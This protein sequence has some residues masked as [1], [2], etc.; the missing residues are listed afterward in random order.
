[1]APTL[2]MMSW[3]LVVAQRPA[4]LAASPM[5][6]VRAT[7]MGR[8][9]PRMKEPRARLMARRAAEVV[10]VRNLSV[11][12]GH[13]RHAIVRNFRYVSTEYRPDRSVVVTVESTRP[14]W[15]GPH[16]PRHPGR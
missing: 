14:A 3:A 1:M 6:V 9:P 2:M 12:L 7:G 15:R 5:V 11:K 4:E 16:C 13:G 10:A 8:P